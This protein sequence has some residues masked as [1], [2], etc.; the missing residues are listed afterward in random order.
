[1][2]FGP[3]LEVW[4]VLLALGVAHALSVLAHGRWRGA[5]AVVRRSR[6]V[7][8]AAVVLTIL[9]AGLFA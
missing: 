4:A 3:T 8:W 1:M 6:Y 7:T 2:W 9:G 5:P